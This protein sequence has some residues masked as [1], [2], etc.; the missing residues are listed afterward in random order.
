MNWETH[1]KL[2]LKDPKFRKAL[3]E[4]RVEYEIA[5]AIILAR[6]KHKLTQ[7]QLA[8]KLKTK[9]SVI[10]RVENAQ[11]TPTISFLQRLATSFGGELKVS[12]EGI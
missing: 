12:F 7:K 11:T 10:S 1:K 9:Q 3:K 5:R 8:R 6:L 2:L 4:T